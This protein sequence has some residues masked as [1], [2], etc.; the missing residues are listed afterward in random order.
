MYATLGRAAETVAVSKRI[1][2]IAHGQDTVRNE[3]DGYY[4]VM[5]LIR[6]VQKTSCCPKFRTT[7][8]VRVRSCSPLKGVAEPPTALSY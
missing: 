5:P 8:E 7:N 4:D 2:E 6:G 1:Y 3:G